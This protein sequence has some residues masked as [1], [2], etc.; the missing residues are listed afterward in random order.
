AAPAQASSDIPTVGEVPSTWPLLSS[1]CTATS[2]CDVH[3]GRAVSK[4]RHGNVPEPESEPGSV[5]VITCQLW[6][7]VAPFQLAQTVTSLFAPRSAATAGG[8]VGVA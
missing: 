2:V 7:A 4:S 8:V 1:A 3:T 5:P 6:T